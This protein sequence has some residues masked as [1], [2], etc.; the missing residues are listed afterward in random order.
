MSA[1]AHAPKP[2][3][4][5]DTPPPRPGRSRG[6]SFTTL[7]TTMALTGTIMAVFVTIHM[8]G[9]LKA[10]MGVQVYNSYAAWLREV[11]YP[12]LPY[13]GLLWS[14]GRSGHFQKIGRAVHPTSW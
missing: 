6:P 14:H 2:A 13:E 11:A 4:L 3:R 8:V 10:F 12:L 5:G 9:N 7:K 1:I